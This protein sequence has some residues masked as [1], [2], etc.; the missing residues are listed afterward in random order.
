VLSASTTG[1]VDALVDAG[2]LGRTPHPT[3][4]RVVLVSLTDRGARL[5]EG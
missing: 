3:D 5:F 2:F 1:L 4:R